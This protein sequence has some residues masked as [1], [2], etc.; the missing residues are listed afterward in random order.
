MEILLVYLA[1]I[2]FT[3]WIASSKGRSVPGWLFLA[4]VLGIFATIAVAL[5]PAK[6]GL[7]NEAR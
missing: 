3:G 7:S 4:A 6:Q 1:V 5:M 2:G